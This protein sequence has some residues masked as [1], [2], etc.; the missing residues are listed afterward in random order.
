MVDYATPPCDRGGTQLWLYS[1][2]VRADEPDGTRGT[3][4]FYLEDGRVRILWSG[5]RW[6][7]CAPEDLL[8]YEPP[9]KLSGPC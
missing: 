2:V 6:E 1:E 7:D 3:L 4:R 8:R 9:D 5:Y